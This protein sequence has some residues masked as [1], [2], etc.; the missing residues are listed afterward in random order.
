M[1]FSIRSLS[2]QESRVVLSLTE[3]GRRE[4]DR[5]EVI[6]ILGITPKAA[7]HIIHS[8]RHKGWLARASWGKYLLIPP[9]HG[10]EALGDSNLLAL[11]SRIADPYYIGFGSAANHYG[12]TTQHRNVIWLVTPHRLRDRRIGGEA[13]VR[14]VNPAP[15]KFFGFAPVDV[16]GYEV[17]MSDR[18]KTAIDCIDRPELCGG[19]GEAAYILATA[20]RRLAWAKAVDYLEQIGAKSLAQRFGWLADHAGAEIPPAQRER[21]VQMTRQARR[22]DFGPAEAISNPLGTDN[23]WRIHVNLSREDL[24]ASAGL[25]RRRSIRGGA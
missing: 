19:E 18:E 15:R 9:D 25:A 20:C 23:T 21:L 11:A 1:D 4:F 12:L 5:A 10:P 24:Q 17:M 2:A 7:D 13:E 22:T 8:L 3:Q 6:S 14:I 16:L